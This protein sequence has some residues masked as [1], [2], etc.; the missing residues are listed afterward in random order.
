MEFFA[1]LSSLQKLTWVFICLMLSWGLEA[2]IPFRKEAYGKWRHVLINL[3]FFVFVLLINVGF[4]LVTLQILNWTEAHQFGLLAMI[5]LPLWLE[6]II[7]V[8]FLDLVAQYLVH[9]LLHK[10]HWMWRL[11]L[12]HHSDTHVDAS[13]GTRHHPLD[14]VLR[15]TF[16]AGAL[17]LLGAP[18][19]FYVFY[20]LLTVLFTY[21]THAN[22]RLPE[23]IDR[24]LS[25]IFVTPN[26]HKFHHHNKTIWTDSNYGNV[27]S[28]WDR[29]FGTFIYDDPDRIVYGVDVMDET[30]DENVWHQLKVPFGKYPP[31][32]PASQDENT[33]RSMRNF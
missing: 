20:R 25:L 32:P 21:V 33:P 7:T 3:I 15:E 16:A 14:Y 11:H 1:D 12:V 10:V 5:H 17:F 4:G 9:V 26:L 31:S 8:V 23:R 2:G 18:F 30:K 28:I 24:A 27:L 6:L 29:I 19:G 13:T 22:I